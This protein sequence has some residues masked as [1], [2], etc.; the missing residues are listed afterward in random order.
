MAKNLL[1]WD[2]FKTNGY[3]KISVW[4]LWAFKLMGLDCSEEI[5]NL[6]ANTQKPIFGSFIAIYISVF[7]L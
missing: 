4:L 2:V 3:V 5:N 1:I 6:G 7:D